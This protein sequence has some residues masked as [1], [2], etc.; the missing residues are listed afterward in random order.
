MGEASRRRALGLPPRTQHMG[1]GKQVQVDL[2]NATKKECA[3]GCKF[4]EP[5]CEVYSV[6]ALVSPTGQDLTVQKPVFVCI[7]CKTLLE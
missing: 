2:N 7:L 4:F 3:C 1:N 5:V 6:S